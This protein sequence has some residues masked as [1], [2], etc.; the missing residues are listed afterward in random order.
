MASSAPLG[1]LRAILCAPPV[2]GDE[3]TCATLLGE[4]NWA[5]IDEKNPPKEENEACSTM[6]TLAV[7]SPEDDKASSEEP[8][9]TAPKFSARVSAAIHETFVARAALRHT[10]SNSRFSVPASEMFR[11]RFRTRH[12]VCFPKIAEFRVVLDRECLRVRIEGLVCFAF[13]PM[14]SCSF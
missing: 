7:A 9:Q 5:K 11:T 12:I 13:H 1:C 10:A 3:L 4:R 6:L 2:L 14:S 8:Q